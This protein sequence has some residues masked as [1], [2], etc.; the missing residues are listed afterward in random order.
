MKTNKIALLFVLPVLLSS[1]ASMLNPGHQEVMINT[2][3]EEVD[4]Y[5]EGYKIGEGPKLKTRFERD[6]GDPQLVLKREGYKNEYRVLAQYKLSP[7]KAL[8]W[9]PF[10]AFLLIPPIGDVD[11]NTRNY[12]DNYKFNV[13]QKLKERQEE[14]KY[15]LAKNSIFDLDK[16]DFS[17]SYHDYKNYM[18]NNENYNEEMAEET[19]TPKEEIKVNDV[20]ITDSLNN[21]LNSYGYM[22]TTNSF[23][24][25]NNDFLY[26]NS[27]VKDVHVSRIQV[28]N[29]DNFYWADFVVTYADIQWEVLSAYEEKL[30]SFTTEVQSGEFDPGFYDKAIHKSIQD[31]IH[32]GFYELMNNDSLRT[33]L[34]RPNNVNKAFESQLK[35]EAGRIPSDLPGAQKAVVTIT[36]DNGHGSGC[37]VGKNGHIL[38]NYH[39]AS[40]DDLKVILDDN[41]RYEPTVVRSNKNA[42]LAILKIDKNFD[43]TFKLPQ[44]AKYKAGQT[45]YSIGTPSSVELGQTL[46][47]GIISGVRENEDWK[48]IQ[49]DASV[50]PGN[51]GGALVNE[52]GELIGIVNKKATGFGVEGVGF[53]IPAE[54]TIETL[55]LSY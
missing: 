52:N 2:G 26:I 50:N 34:E 13:T 11:D 47:K 27:L 4:I 55:S 51:S 20:S 36:N 38:T 37:V 43:V 46:S 1:C 45:V 3:S 53:S 18:K 28:K 29:F 9:F 39:V 6:A 12:K 42:D 33:L 14:E 32:T 48:L 10:G 21:T 40:E 8:S 25:I 30:F 15:V 44:E 22:D 19:Y 23:V 7:W 49:M 24:S 5:K 35:F 17:I 41:K 54:K 31:A 16:N